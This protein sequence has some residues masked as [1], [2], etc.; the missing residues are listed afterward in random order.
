MYLG[1]ARKTFEGGTWLREGTTA[2]DKRTGAGEATSA[3]VFGRLSFE[4]RQAPPSRFVRQSPETFMHF[5]Q[6]CGMQVKMTR[7]VRMSESLNARWELTN[8]TL[9]RENSGGN[10]WFSHVALVAQRK[11]IWLSP[12]NKSARPS[13]ASSV[14]Q[15]SEAND[16]S[17]YIFSSGAGKALAKCKQPQVLKPRMEHRGLSESRNGRV[18]N[19][20]AWPMRVHLVATN[21]HRC[22][23]P[24][25]NRHK[26]RHHQYQNPPPTIPR[27][28]H[29]QVIPY[30]QP[31][32]HSF[33]NKETGPP[34]THRCM[35]GD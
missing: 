9:L 30:P 25:I 23:S 5:G 20:I 17:R 21:R 13:H 4:I 11:R 19:R 28:Q 18:F 26:R 6:L 29:Q 27:V 3:M 10:V 14:E 1:S 31:H 16:A 8:A 33:G 35:F 2:M 24:K 32:H 22:L 15:R 34:V 12:N 7:R